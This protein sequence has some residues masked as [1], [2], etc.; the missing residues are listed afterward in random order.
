MLKVNKNIEVALKALEVLKNETT[1]IRSQNIAEKIGS[2]TSYVEQVV[3]KLRVA[4]FTKAVRGPGGGYI[5]NRG[6]TITALNVAQLFGYNANTTNEGVT[7]NLAQALNSAFE[8]TR[9]DL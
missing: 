3:R 8:N 9:I 5:A 1:P 7:G 6:Q 4:G 2:T